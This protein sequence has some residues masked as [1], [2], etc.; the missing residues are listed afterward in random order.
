MI[1]FSPDFGQRHDGLPDGLAGPVEGQLG[2]QRTGDLHHPRPG[3]E[4]P[5]PV[6]DTSRQTP[7]QLQ[8]AIPSS[9]IVFRVLLFF[10]KFKIVF[11]NHFIPRSF[12]HFID[13][14]V[15]SRRIFSRH[16]IITLCLLDRPPPPPLAHGDLLSE[17]EGDHSDAAHHAQ[18]GG[19]VHHGW[20]AEVMVIGG[21]HQA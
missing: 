7:P 20:A 3:V 16:I 1:L 5:D 21:G 9:A 10:H 6:L 4:H 18:P 15:L 13:N 14:I 8:S 12:S 19:A 11:M 2:H 17:K